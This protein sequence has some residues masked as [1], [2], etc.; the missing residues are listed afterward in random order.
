ME[1]VGD[2]VVT[3]PTRPPARSGLALLEEE[4]VVTSTSAQLATIW[5]GLAELPAKS[6]PTR[7]P[8]RISW[9]WLPVVVAVTRPV[10]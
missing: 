3:P 7:P 4:V 6:S 5:E 8:A 10:A 2:P 1:G 9:E